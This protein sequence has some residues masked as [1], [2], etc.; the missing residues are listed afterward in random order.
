MER[1][2]EKGILV[3]PDEL[4]VKL[5]DKCQRLGIDVIGIHPTGGVDAK[6]SLR[7]LTELL[8]TSEFR[9]L[10]DYAHRCK[11]KIEYEAHAVSYLL[12][13]ELFHEHPEY[14]RM[15]E[16]GERRQSVNFCVSSKEALAIVEKNTA[17]LAKK[18]YGSTNRFYFWFDDVREKKCCCDECS[19]LSISDQQ[20]IYQNAVL[21]GIRSVIPDARVCYLAYMDC[22]YQP[23]VIKPEDGIFLEYAPFEKYVSKENTELVR[24]EHELISPLL[25]FFGRDD[26]KVLEYWLDNSLYSKWKKPPKKFSADGEAIV[27]DIAEYADFGF[28]SIATF[29]CF[30]GDDYEELYGEADISPF[31]DAF[32]ALDK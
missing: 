9:T 18:L 32:K 12:P 31:T 26:S 2:T 10:I 15:N 25:E 20:L 6:D 3:H 5:I 28:E 23:S 27:R 13:R 19:K 14:F 24:R 4:T 11:I 16:S 30:L 7:A 22:M 1:K 17:E 21:R 8:A 29:A